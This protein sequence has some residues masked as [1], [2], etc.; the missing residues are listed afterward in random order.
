MNL[1]H[2][3][4]GRLGDQDRHTLL[5]QQVRLLSFGGIDQ[6]TMDVQ[7]DDIC[8]FR[9][10]VGRLDERL[11]LTEFFE[12]RLDGLVGYVRF[13]KSQPYISVAS[14]VDLGRQW[15]GVP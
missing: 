2:R 7:D 9:R 4:I 1:R 13:F 8:E 15:Y 12:H 10:T 5:I 11:P 14:Q 6:F 3:P